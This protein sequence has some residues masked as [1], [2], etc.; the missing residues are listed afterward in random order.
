MKSMSRAQSTPGMTGPRFTA[1]SPKPRLSGIS[2][3]VKSM[4]KMIA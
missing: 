4:A 1:S 2:T 3:T